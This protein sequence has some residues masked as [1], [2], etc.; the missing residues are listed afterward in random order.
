ME[1]KKI[2]VDIE[3]NSEDIKKS[4][5]AMGNAAKEAA[6]LTAK[7][8]E[9]KTE[10]QA[11]A[12]AAKAGAISATELASRQAGL[13]LK[14]TETSKALAASN[15][16]YAN[17]KIVVD[18][19]K[20][21]NEQLRARLALQTKAYNG[22]SKAQREN[23]KGG[24]QMEANIKA[25]TDKLKANEKAVGDNRRNVGNYGDALKGAVNSLKNFASA[26]GITAGIAALSQVLKGAVKIAKDFEQGNANLASVLGKTS[27]E[28][29]NLTDDAKRLGAATSFSATQVSQLQTEFAKLGFNEQEI[30]NATEATLNLAAA[31]GSELGEA[32]AI[33]GATLGGFGLDAAE[34]A[35]VT[36][37]MAKSFSTSALDLEK[38]KE[39]MK[40]AAP[41]AKAVGVS[42]EKT[43]ALLGTLA[44]AGISG[45]KAGNNLKTSF[46]NLNA[47][48]LTLEQGLEKVAN[49]EDKLGTAAELV[50]KNAAASFLVLADGV[51]VTK[52]LEQGLNDAGGAAQKM[53]D[54]QLNTLEG[55]TKILNSAWEGLILS[56]LSGDGV[57]SNL[58]KGLVEMATGLLSVLT[59]AEEL[60]STWYAQRDAVNDLE[61]SLTP[62]LDRYDELATQTELTKDEQEELDS[63]ILKVS[64]DV[65]KAITAF[66]EYGKAMD[67]STD[68]ARGLIQQQKDLLALDNAKAIEEQQDAIQGLNRDLKQLNLT[69]ILQDNTLKRVRI[70]QKSGIK[71]IEDAT[72]SEIRAFQK[73]SE[74]I[75]KGLEVRTAK[76]AK[77]KGEQT[78]LEKLAEAEAKSAIEKV[79]IIKE[80]ADIEV[81]TE[82]ELAAELAKIWR[83]KRKMIDEAAEADKNNAIATIENAEERAEKIAFIEREALFQKLRSI[84][85]ETAARTAAAD[86]IG[87]VDEVK[88]A[89]QL[90]ERAKYEAE[91]A[92]ID[93]AARAEEFTSKIEALALDEKLDNEAAELSIDN[94]RDLTQRKGVIALGYLTQKL[95][96]MRALAEADDLLT[97][98]EIKNLQLVE[99]KI[100]RIQEG[101][102]NPESKTLGQSIGLGD[103]DLSKIQEGLELATQAIQTIQMVVDANA[104]IRLNE[105]DE[106]NN[107]EIRAIESSTLSEEKKDA[108]IKAINKKAA[109]EKYAIELQQFKTAKALAII[110]AIVNTATAV[111][112]QLSNPVP[113]TGFVL[114]ALAAVTGAVQIG[115]IA[116]QKPP[117]PPKFA[118][119][120]VLKG[121]SHAEG[122]IQMYGNGQ[123]YGEAE[124]GEI[125]LTK[126]VNANP[127]LRAEASRLNVLGGGNPLGASNYMADGGIVSPTFAARQSA[128][129]TSMSK[130]DF[131]DV[132]ADMPSPSVQVSEINRVQGQVVRVSETSDL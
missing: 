107:A 66:D 122:G 72:S 4:T 74:E 104:E 44:N 100:K 2:I 130:Q 86:M 16:D 79:E 21:S 11:N 125:V 39:S 124:G 25:L 28:I 85:D 111:M 12:K 60:E 120:G 7:L 71:S 6:V 119:G 87:A 76:I 56:L 83:G 40:G 115:V 73:E 59:P 19:A 110:M 121:A 9:L 64:D 116:S 123:H 128:R 106:R 8:N 38:F 57:F 30:L 32:A 117:P 22:L 114:A 126:G 3:I 41:A 37:V 131:A 26:L 1:A 80:V 34:T 23:T 75:K 129:G 101:L 52:E 42:V 97:E 82:E 105:I 35:R 68:A 88:Y 48:G 24:K 132:I 53:A 92:E 112:A 43:T 5:D 98:N 46:I 90:A 10:Q 103:E 14:M 84:E 36:D 78:E 45:S 58:S 63:I 33:A 27:S 31:T 77:L 47:A 102:D 61:S 15:K 91:L 96:L 81:K 62:L 109:Q 70:N 89:K 99:N 49:S 94:E 17:N 54:E 13:K 67:I 118:K 18:A 51:G 108:K 95:E 127:R 50:G 69:Y 55:K 113:F 93:R 20:G 29:T 65:P